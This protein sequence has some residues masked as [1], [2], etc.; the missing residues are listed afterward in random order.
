MA[1]KIANARMILTEKREQ[2]FKRSIFKL[3]GYSKDT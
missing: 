3:Y 1:Q 2:T